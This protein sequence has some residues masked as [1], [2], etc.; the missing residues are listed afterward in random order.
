[1]TR[2]AHPTRRPT[3]EERAFFD[4]LVALR[5]WYASR[6]SDDGIAVATVRHVIAAANAEMRRSGPAPRPQTFGIDAN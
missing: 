1:M 6:G 2:P 5:T 4:D 3:R